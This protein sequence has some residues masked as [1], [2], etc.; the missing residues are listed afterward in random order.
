MPVIDRLLP[1]DRAAVIT[2]YRRV[3]G[4]DLADAN[5][6]RW[7][8]QYARNPNNPSQGPQI[9]VAR[10]GPAIVGQYATMPVRLWVRNQEVDASWGMDVMV[11]PERQRQGLG[12]LLFHTWDAHVGASLGLGLSDSSSRLFRKLRWPTPG[13]VPCLVKPLS[14]RAFRRAN[15]PTAVNRLVSA[16]TLPVVKFVSRVRPL[17]V[18]VAVTREFGDGFT[19]LWDRVAPKFD[20]AVKRDAPY[21]H[22]KYLLP[23]HV[24]YLVAVAGGP[25]DPRGYVVYRHVVEP[26]GRVTLLVDF[27]CDPD[28]EATFV[29][30]LGWV[31]REARS[32]DSDK[33]RGFAMHA[34]FRHLLKR[35]GY[36]EVKSTMEF[37]AKINAATVP[38]AFYRKTDRWHVTL[39]DSDQDR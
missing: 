37:V 19:R 27:L 30:L 5:D 22:W 28:D 24:R 23:P 8:W 14:R 13:P 20:F 34:G 9:W 4:G 26:R 10:E 29:T 31:D 1:G 16:A 33:I 12:E 25:D 39:G 7:D 18:E 36:F 11:A 38:E 6:L 15:W 3:F 32:N 35:S 21:L 17:R 2:L